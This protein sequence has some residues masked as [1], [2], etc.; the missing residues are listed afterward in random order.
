MN[1]FRLGALALLVVGCGATDPAPLG[2]STA[3]PTLVASPTSNTPFHLRGRVT[4]E[5]RRPT[6]TGASHETDERPARQVRVEAR[7]SADVVLAS[8]RTDA[9]GEYVLD[10][11]GDVAQLA[12]VAEVDADGRLLSVAFDELG[13]RVHAQRYQLPPLSEREEWDGHLHAEADDALGGALHILDTLMLGYATVER[14]T[15]ERLPALYV[16][17]GPDVTVDWSYYRGERTPGRFCLELLA[18]R[19]AERM[20]T[21]TDEHDEAIVLHELGHF[22]FDRWTGHSSIGGRHPRGSRVDTGVAWEEGRATWLATAILR[23]PAYV[24]SRG[25]EGTGSARVDEIVETP[26]APRGL[27]SETSVAG[28]LW[29]LS[30]GVESDGAEADRSPDSDGDGLYLGPAAVLRGMISV[31][32]EPSA[33][34]GLGTFLRHL[35]TTNVVSDAA[36]RAM[37]RAS[38]EPEAVLDAPWPLELG[39]SGPSSSVRGHI[40]GMTQPAPSGGEN[41][42]ENGYDAVLAYRVIVGAPGRLSLTLTPSGA[43]TSADHTDLSL[44]LRN[45]HAEP[46]GRSANAAGPESLTL[47]V[48]AGTY[49]V[50]VRDAGTGNLTDFTLTA[51][52]VP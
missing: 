46:I 7:S 42:A 12:V 16:Y 29:D 27:G 52:L 26:Q 24:D 49:V 1:P 36:L 23:D 37:L 51:S 39:T 3:D 48:A 11:I 9:H 35:V 17:W 50:Y 22:V 30:D 15:G 31:S 20:T 34:V 13:T 38:G 45:D 18:G 5:A 8:V 2:T 28:V 25:I 10:G 21:D 44:E 40:D 19:R 6:S 41:R 4:F 33:Y 43:G 47:P 32:R 14:W